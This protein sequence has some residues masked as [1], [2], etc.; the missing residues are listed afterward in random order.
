MIRNYGD[1]CEELLKAGFSVASGGN[2][3]GVFGLLD[4]G[5]D[6]QPPGSPIR[7][8]TGDPET[9]PW[10]WRMR[11]LDE[12]GDI[13]YAKVFFRKG[14]YIT[15]EWYPYFLAARRGGKTL[16]DDYEDGMVSRLAKCIYEVV[17]ENASLPKHDIKR[18]AGISRKD[19][20]KFEGALV[21]LQMKLYLTICGSRQK[22]TRQGEE[23][24]WS[25]TVFCTVEQ[26]WGED[27]LGKA[28]RLRADDAARRIMEQ[29]H[30]LNPHADEKKTARFIKG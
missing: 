28:A 22:R 3:E 29:V 26:F 20:A 10:E 30:L 8:H 13:A 24:G 6:Q 5:W 25:S 16:A 21:E 19:N 9:D 2:D 17:E 12:R 14:G 1:F 18:L 15:K 23:Y 11:V 4:H 27:V 7:W